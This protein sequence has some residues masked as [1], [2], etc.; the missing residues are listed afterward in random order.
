LFSTRTEQAV[1]KATKNL[2]TRR[3]KRPMGKLRNSW[4]TYW[5]QMRLSLASE[6]N[7][8]VVRNCKAI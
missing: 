6:R 5:T 2:K 7:Y 3:S 1:S 8:L 4:I